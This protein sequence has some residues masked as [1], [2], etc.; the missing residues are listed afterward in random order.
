MLRVLV[1]LTMVTTPAF[2]IN[3]HEG[4]LP[5]GQKDNDKRIRCECASKYN[6]VCDK[7]QNHG[8]C[9][10]QNGAVPDINACISQRGGHLTFPW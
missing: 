8:A 3:G 10:F 7:M 1:I 9:T 4:F 5:C 2:A 6:V